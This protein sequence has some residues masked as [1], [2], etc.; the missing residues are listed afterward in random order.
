MKKILLICSILSICLLSGCTGNSNIDLKSGEKNSSSSSLVSSGEVNNLEDT[1]NS[2][3][4]V[5]KFLD[6]RDVWEDVEYMSEAF[7]GIYSVGYG[8][9]DIDNDGEK[10]LA[11]Q[12]GGGTMLNC[13]TIFYKVVNGEVIRKN[14]L[15][16][17]QSLSIT[18]LTKYKDESGNEFFI[19]QYRLKADVTE[20]I[21]F[22]DELTVIN[23]K[24]DI[25]NLFESIEKY[26]DEETVTNTYYSFNEELDEDTFNRRK[27][28]YFNTLTKIGEKAEI[29]SYD[30]WKNMSE[31]EKKDALLNLYNK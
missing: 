22:I 7:G 29:V 31:N 3:E 6:S 26:K 23:G 18:D 8:F 21:T 5:S 30:E 10:E 2:E 1:K 9:F 20:Y 25:K 4:I 27:D 28:A 24:I 11:V 13:S 17:D 12:Y 16:E 15:P 14:Y 19:N